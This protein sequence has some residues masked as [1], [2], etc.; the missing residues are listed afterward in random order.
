MASAV[1]SGL[2]LDRAAAWVQLG[3]LSQEGQPPAMEDLADEA[4]EVDAESALED[5]VGARM[6]ALERLAALQA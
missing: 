1:R 5:R 2:P 4:E 3:V 6:Q